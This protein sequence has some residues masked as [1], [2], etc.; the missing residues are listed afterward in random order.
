MITSWLKVSNK[1]A[2]AFSKLAF[3]AADNKEA[4]LFITLYPERISY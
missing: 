4:M 2:I 3:C 1:L